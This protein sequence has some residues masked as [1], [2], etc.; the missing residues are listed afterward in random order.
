M[1]N[2]IA[3]FLVL[4]T[5]CAWPQAP[6]IPDTPAGHALQTWLDVFNS[7]DRQRVQEYVKKYDPRLDDH[8]MIGVPEGR[9]INPVSKKDWEGTGV[10][11]DV[12]V[13][14]DQALDTARKMAAEEIQKKVTGDGAQATG[15]SQ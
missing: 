3:L 14:A 5:V 10:E 7:G 1:L 12:K 4:V 13:P 11:P 8:F 2:R 6:A 15:K 9:P